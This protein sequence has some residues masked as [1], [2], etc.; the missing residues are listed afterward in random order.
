[1]ATIETQL[2]SCDEILKLLKENTHRSQNRMK[3]YTNLK[4]I[5][6][7]FKEGEWVYLRLQPY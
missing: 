3:K 6:H 7:Y 4:R 1:L 5:E 2:R